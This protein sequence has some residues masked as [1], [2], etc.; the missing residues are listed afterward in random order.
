[1]F[2]PGIYIHVFVHVGMCSQSD[3]YMC[4][5]AYAHTYMCTHIYLY[6]RAYTYVYT[7]MY[8]ERPFLKGYYMPIPE[9]APLTDKVTTV[10]SESR[11]Q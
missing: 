3:M 8:C 9:R 6:M 5:C 4:W 11:E 1:M 2:V 7:H 10:H